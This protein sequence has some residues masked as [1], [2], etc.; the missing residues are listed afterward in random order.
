MSKALAGKSLLARCAEKGILKEEGGVRYAVETVAGRTI[1]ALWVG[2]GTATSEYCIVKTE[3]RA[4]EVV[5]SYI[6]RVAATARAKA[7]RRASAKVAK[8]TVAKTVTVG[9]IF[10]YSWG[11][12]QTNIDYYEVVRVSPTGGTV[13]VREIASKVIEQ[14]SWASARVAPCPG[15]FVEKAPEIKKV[16]GQYGISFAHG[17]GHVVKEGETHHSSWGH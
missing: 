17:S 4:A 14:T 6:E 12:E 2:K 10:C 16:V 13:W 9:T 3:E 15:Q 1:L 5:K 7:E 8:A 11:Y